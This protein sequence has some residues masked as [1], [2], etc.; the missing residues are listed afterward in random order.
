[1]KIKRVVGKHLCFEKVRRMLSANVDPVRSR[2][3]CRRELLHLHAS[4][5][6]WADGLRGLGT[7]YQNRSDVAVCGRSHTLFGFATLCDMLVEHAGTHMYT[8]LE[9]RVA[10]V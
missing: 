1:M 3:A 8:Y 10:P 4:H 6:G 7:A 5:T 9:R 2:G